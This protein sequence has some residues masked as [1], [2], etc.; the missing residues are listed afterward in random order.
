LS[1]QLRCTYLIALLFAGLV[2]FRIHGSSIAIPALVWDPEHAMDHFVAAPIL[3]QLEPAEAKRW[4]SPL[5]AVPRN[6]RVDEWSHSTP[7]ALAQ[8]H[9]EPQFPVV[10]TNIGDG[11]NMLVSPWVPVLHPSAIARPVTWGYLLFGSQAGLAWAWWYQPLA[12]F[13]A[14]VFLFQILLPQQNLLAVFGAAWYCA[15]A[16]VICWSLWPAYLTSFGAFAVVCA[17]HLMRSRHRNVLLAAG[18]GLGMSFSGF[19]LQLYPPWQ[20]PLAHVF[21]FVFVGLLIRDRPWQGMRALGRYRLLGLGLGLLVAAVALGSFFVSTARVLHAMADTVYPGQRRLLGGDCSATRL[22]ASFYNNWTI[23]KPPSNSNES[24]TAGFFLLFPAVIIAVIASPR[25][26]SRIGPVGWL[27]LALAGFFVYFCVTPIPA[28]LADVTLMSRAQGFR[29]QIALGLVSIILCMQLLAA[30]QRR[31]FWDERTLSTAVLVFLGCGGLYVWFGW[32]FQMETAYFPGGS[33][34]PPAEV[35]KVS[36]FAASVCA[37]MALG[38]RWVSAVAVLSAAVLTA[39]TFNPLSR[40]FTPLERTEMGRA[41]A[42][43]VRDDPKPG[44]QPSLWLTYGGSLYPSMGMVAQMLGARSI[45]GVH[46]HPQIDMWRKIDPML[47]HFEKYNRYALVL[48][49]PASPSDSTLF[50]NLPHMFVLHI[51]TS[52]LHPVWRNLGARYVFNYGPE[53]VL[54]ESNLVPVYAAKS[55]AFGI[56]QL[57]DVPAEQPH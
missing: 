42:S 30:M 9:H 26:R 11:A 2:A 1:F 32:Y 36:C 21:L 19:V 40:G 55:G 47:R 44:G 51:K 3:S 43:V 46:Q 56:W 33:A 57:P 23:F 15:S 54:A 6:I 7:W 13:L 50:F 37:C 28:W 34:T 39:G 4:S 48:Q 25:A 16:Y 14:L 20:V 38:L 18:V 24:E 17:Y 5:M 8:F 27:M 31:R 10:N 53:G 29:S 49:F 22:L 52:P 41:I 45:G 35:L 12:C